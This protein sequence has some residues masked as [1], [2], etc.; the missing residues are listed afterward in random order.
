MHNKPLIS[1]LGMLDTKNI[2]DLEN[3]L[4]NVADLEVAEV[5]LET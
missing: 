1:P 3:K 2:V 5:L 4:G